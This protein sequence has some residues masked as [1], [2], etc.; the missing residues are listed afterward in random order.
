MQKQH[1]THNFK[2]VS[3]HG[4]SKFEHLLVF[5][6][7]TSIPKLWIKNNSKKITKSELMYI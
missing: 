6:I 4:F 2:F 1:L 7:Y 3:L 5:Y